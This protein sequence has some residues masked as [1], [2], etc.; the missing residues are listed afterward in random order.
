MTHRKTGVV[1]AGT[2]HGDLETDGSIT[3]KLTS[4]HWSVR[5]WIGLNWLN[6]DRLPDIVNT[7]M[8]LRVP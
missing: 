3:P 7:V 1:L 8:N 5:K 2:L 4:K 6:T